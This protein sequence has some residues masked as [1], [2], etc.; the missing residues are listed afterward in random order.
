[1]LRNF[2][3]HPTLCKEHCLMFSMKE[4]SFEVFKEIGSFHG[5]VNY[6]QNKRF[7]QH[8]SVQ[9]ES[10]FETILK[11]KGEKWIHLVLAFHYT[12]NREYYINMYV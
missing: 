8:F 6:I 11:S 1:M 12:C 10:I 5:Q 7:H 4:T 2:R 3:K 9:E